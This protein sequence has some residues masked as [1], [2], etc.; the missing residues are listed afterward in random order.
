MNSHND[1][2]E[3]I[4]RREQDLEERER[5]IRL[6][7]L[8]AEIHQAAAED[9]RNPSTPAGEPPLYP[10][11]KHEEPEGKLKRW[12]RK[13][14]NIAKFSAVIL[15]TIVVISAGALIAKWIVTGLMVL[16]VGWFAYKFFL[17]EERPKR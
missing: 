17:E 9:I 10:T 16:A 11:R 4:R 1:K 2:D 12:R 3:E 8:E 6:R 14:A 13:L 15:G 5:A 7:E